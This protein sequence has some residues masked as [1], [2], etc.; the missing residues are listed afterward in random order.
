VNLIPSEGL[1]VVEEVNKRMSRPGG[2]RNVSGFLMVR[3]SVVCVGVC[4]GGWGCMCMPARVCA[5]V[6]ACVCIFL[7]AFVAYMCVCHAHI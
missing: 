1:A 7:C 4:V 2:L 5:R 6:F 3:S